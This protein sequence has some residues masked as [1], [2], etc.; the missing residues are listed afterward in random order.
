M[1]ME[2]WTLQVLGGEPAGGTAKELAVITASLLKFQEATR[3]RAAREHAS[4]PKLPLKLFTGL[5]G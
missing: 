3:G 2:I 4:G 5:L 1:L